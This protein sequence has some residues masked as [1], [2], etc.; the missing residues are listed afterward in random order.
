MKRLETE[1]LILRKFTV[2][3]AEDMYKNWCSDEKVT[4]FLSFNPH[5]SAEATREL[6]VGWVAAYEKG[7]RNWVVQLKETGEIIGSISVIA[8][9]KKHGT[10]EVGYV[11][12]YNYWGNGYGTE[13]LRAVL[14][15]L[16]CECN[17]C[18]VE[19]KHRSLNPASGRVMQKSGMIKDGVLRKRVKSKIDDG[20]DDLIV[21]SIT[22]EDRHDNM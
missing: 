8:E 13:A 16:L 12:G 6:L 9:S 1:R 22:K 21:Y 11:Y 4:R 3:D 10:C 17:F 14:E 18:L 5:E 7:A 20:Y 2:D 15:Y 19:A